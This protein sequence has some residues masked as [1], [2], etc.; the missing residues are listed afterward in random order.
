MEKEPAFT[1]ELPSPLVD[2]SEAAAA[3][4]SWSIRTKLQMKER[5]RDLALFNFGID[6]KLR[7]SDV[8]AV[9]VD[10]VA[11][12]DYAMDRATVR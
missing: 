8:V 2:R 12:S 7:G 11:A 10:D 3:A 1:D 6:S 9:R 4:K 5:N